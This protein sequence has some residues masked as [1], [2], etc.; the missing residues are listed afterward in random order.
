M[1]KIRLYGDRK[2]ASSEFFMKETLWLFEST[3]TPK[4]EQSPKNLILIV[5]K[6]LGKQ[7]DL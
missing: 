6:L 2:S 4:E 5:S 1:L 7:V 3:I